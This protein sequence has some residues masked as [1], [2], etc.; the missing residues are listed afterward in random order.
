MKKT[1]KVGLIIYAA[2]L[3]LVVLL[4]ATG[5]LK[6]QKNSGFHQRTFANKKLLG[7]HLDLGIS[8]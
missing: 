7:N 3:I 4:H 5:G 6:A 8:W 2:I 1:I